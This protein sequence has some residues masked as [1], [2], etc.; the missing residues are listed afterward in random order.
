MKRYWAIVLFALLACGSSATATSYP[1]AGLALVTAGATLSH[2]A[3]TTW[4]LEKTGETGDS[5]V[6]WSVEAI[7]GDT[8][9]DLLVVNGLLT[10][11]NIGR[12]P[13]TIGNVVVN[14]QT[15]FGDRWVTESSVVADAT[16]DDAATSANIAPKASSE[17]LGTFTENAASG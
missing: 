14:L 10:L 9:T 8:Q 7:E 4:T 16:Q 3:D 5:A 17:G 11:I 1:R 12:G 6:V 15:R 2:I 13:A